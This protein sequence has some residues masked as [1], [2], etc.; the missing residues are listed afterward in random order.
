MNIECTLKHVNSKLKYHFKSCDSSVSAFL[1][2]IDTATYP[3]RRLS[4][5]TGM[6]LAAFELKERVRPCQKKPRY[7]L[8]RAN[9]LKFHLEDLN[10]LLFF[11][12]TDSMSR[13]KPH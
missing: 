8:R 5:D 1:Q 13:S 7:F 3:D 10:T 11:I 9:I 12:N 2:H 6:F 4:S